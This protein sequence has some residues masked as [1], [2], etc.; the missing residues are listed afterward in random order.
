MS[1][2]KAF[3]ELGAMMSG[4]VKLPA[5]CTKACSGENI[6]LLVTTVDNWS[7]SYDRLEHAVCATCAPSPSTHLLKNK[8]AIACSQ[9]EIHMQQRATN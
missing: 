7:Q 5:A 6:A 3:S 9:P 4:P 2:S 1:C 8:V